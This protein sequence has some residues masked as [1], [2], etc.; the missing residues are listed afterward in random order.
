MDW[1]AIATKVTQLVEEFAPVAET[2]AGPELTA[3]IEIGRTVLDLGHK[4]V[5]VAG[6]DAATL[7]A[8]LPALEA[9]VVAMAQEESAALRG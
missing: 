2:F 5:D 4:V 9:R 3:A 6:A 8:A 1:K 7:E